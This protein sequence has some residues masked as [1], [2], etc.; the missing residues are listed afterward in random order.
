M[1]R[2]AAQS[3]SQTA[4]TLWSQGSEPLRRASEHRR[5]AAGA[6]DWLAGW[7]YGP[8]GGRR[9]R[10]YKPADVSWR[11]R[12]P[13]LVM[14]HGCGQSAE[15]F[16][17]S[18]RMNQLAERERL[19]VLYPEQDRHANQQGC[20]NWFATASGQAQREAQTVLAAID[21][22]GRFYPADL[23]R[24]VVGGLSA[25]AS[26]AALLAA[27]HPA[28]FKAVVM[29]SGVGPGLAETPVQAWAAMRG[30]V[31]APRLGIAAAELGQSTQPVWPPLLVLHGVRD[32]VVSSRNAHWVA[33][34]WADA[35]GAQAAPARRHQRGQRHAMT[36]T[37]Y[38]AGG[39]LVARCCEVEALAHAWSGG[40]TRLAH[41]D[42]QGPNATS[43]LWH[44]VKPLLQGQGGAEDDGHPTEGDL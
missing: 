22:V 29:H 38:K 5:L 14:L 39:R 18:T 26:L 34:H 7:A 31:A 13:L 41:G 3:T 6:G 43:L 16:A 4:A 24:V 15:E 44:F 37:D 9:Y 32:T 40:D 36:V 12:L 1:S 42:A 19:L 8:A 11:E 27:S 25:G 33:Q 28:R 35:Q 10:L 20:W 21:Q 2:L 23:S 17:L 30:R